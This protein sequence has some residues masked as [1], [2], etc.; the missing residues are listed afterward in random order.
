MLDSNLTATFLTD[1]R[2]AAAHDHP[3][4]RRGR[5]GGVGGRT[6]SYRHYHGAY[7]VAKA[8]VVALT[9]H[10]AHGGSTVWDAGQLRVAVG[11]RDAKNVPAAELGVRN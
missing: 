6:H 11:D 4:A 5:D 1:P 3:R 8:G 7:A 2:R 9:R 10:V